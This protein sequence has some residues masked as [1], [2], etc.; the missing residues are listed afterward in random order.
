MHIMSEVCVLLQASEFLSI[1][2]VC[3]AST[4]MAEACVLLLCGPVL[5]CRRG[6]CTM[7][8]CSC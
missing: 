5:P 2:Q 1:H 7:G 6:H 8:W 3:V 4:I